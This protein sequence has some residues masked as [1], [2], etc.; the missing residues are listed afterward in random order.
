MKKR[1]Q[2][3][4]EF[5]DNTIIQAPPKVTRAES[6]QKPAKGKLPHFQQ[7]P[8]IDSPSR[9]DS[10]GKDAQDSR[11]ASANSILH[12]TMSHRSDDNLPSEA[13]TPEVNEK[14]IAGASTSR[15]GSSYSTC[16][17]HIIE[18]YSSVIEEPTE[19]FETLESSTDASDQ[20]LL[21]MEQEVLE[22]MK[23]LE[24]VHVLYLRDELEGEIFLS[25]AVASMLSDESLNHLFF[26]YLNQM[27]H[28]H[29][30]NITRDICI[31]YCN[32]MSTNSDAESWP[33]FKIGFRLAN[34]LM[35]FG[36]YTSV[37]AVLLALINQ[38]MQ[39]PEL[40]NWVAIFDAFVKIMEINIT[41]VNF[42]RVDWANDGAE[43]MR[44]KIQMMS[45][46]KDILD[47]S[48]LRI[49]LSKLM[50]ERGSV[51]PA[52]S[53]AQ[54]ALRV[55]STFMKSACPNCVQSHSVD[56]EFLTVWFYTGCWAM[57]Y[58]EHGWSLVQCQQSSRLGSQR[59]KSEAIG[60][61]SRETG[62]VQCFRHP[63]NAS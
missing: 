47:E 9:A 19:H 7:L 49:E 22:T 62:E 32:F 14:D 52:V 53:L 23:R 40:D 46:G 10:S 30:M 36:Q 63:Q 61:R 56:H 55:G 34:F 24:V 44:R 50:Q 57:E 18:N 37:E 25:E 45:F 31:S 41:N 6:V 38:M 35:G 28:K 3:L 11:V 54:Q 4:I 58:R 60:N 43:E 8:S 21:N 27:K 1:Y 13:K 33:L 48:G 59:H 16:T 20:V 29:R 51:K 2:I 42:Q 15:I 5:L 39:N 17:P 12:T 26:K